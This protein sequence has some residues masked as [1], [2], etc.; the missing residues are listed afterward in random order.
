MADTKIVRQGAQLCLRESGQKQCLRTYRSLLQP[1][2]K[3]LIT[4][5]KSLIQFEEKNAPMGA[6]NRQACLSQN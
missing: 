4:G 3:A 2:Y 5:L 1:I 6:S